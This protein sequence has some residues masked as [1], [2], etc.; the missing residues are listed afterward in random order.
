MSRMTTQS[1][2]ESAFESHYS[3]LYRL[4]DVDDLLPHFV[5]ENI[6]SDSNL[7]ETKSLTS[8]VKM[9]RLL[10]QISGRLK[11][12]NTKGFY[13]M[14]SIMKKHGSETT[15]NLSIAIMNTLKTEYSDDKD[16]KDDKEN[17]SEKDTG[18]ANIAIHLYIYMVCI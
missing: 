1:R 2:E 17:S 14:L 8:F 13:A 10:S 16:D 9:N 5:E 12:G 3:E 6:V 7:D 15:R 18:I 11:T 4:T